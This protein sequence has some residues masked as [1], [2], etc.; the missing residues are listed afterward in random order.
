MS[1]E[2][3]TGGAEGAAK[4]AAKGVAE[5]A[6]G[7]AAT[8]RVA[9]VIPN[10]NGAHLLRGCLDSLR[11]QSLRDF[12]VCVVD[13]GSKDE[14]LVLLAAEYP[15]V[16]VVALPVNVGFASGVNAGIRAT[17]APYVVL[18]NNDTE[19]A[20]DW[21]AELVATMDAHP[22]YAYA[23]SK[24][25]DYKQR[26]IIDC[27]ADGF[28]PIGIPFKVGA[29]ERDVGQYDKPFELFG[30]CAAASLYR[31]SMLDEIGLFDDDWFAYIEDVE[32]SLRAQVAGYRGVA[33]VSAKVFHMGSASSGG[34]PSAFTVRLSARNVWWTIFKCLPAGLLWRVVPA[35]AAAQVVLVFQAL[36][37]GRFPWLRRNFGAFFGGLGDALRG[38]PKVLRK[39]RSVV[40]RIDA[41]E[42]L[43]RMQA[44]GAQQRQS[45]ERLRRQR[46]RSA[47][48]A[49]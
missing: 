38:L 15:E 8:P 31:R 48:A 46:A 36:L 30:A 28:S 32:L 26:D 37:L 1:S 11:R 43:R 13:N 18:L 42:L 2:P 21:L 29:Y 45:R 27:V 24:L 17:R 49:G 34:G 23:A 41:A 3:G 7:H 20:P 5:G 22:Q 6:L 16:E 4:G 40:R 44:G 19:A 12:V 35:A 10:W 33:V 39:R 9:V 25:L 14:S 47:T